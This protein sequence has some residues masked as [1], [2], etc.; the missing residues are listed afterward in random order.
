MKGKGGSIPMLLLGQDGINIRSFWAEL[1]SGIMWDRLA[2]CLK[3]FEKRGHRKIEVYSP[4]R[5]TPKRQ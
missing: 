5:V 3:A 2:D 1:V 4:Q